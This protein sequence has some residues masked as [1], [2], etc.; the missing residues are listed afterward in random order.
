M[1]TSEV[2]EEKI[3]VTLNA[4]YDVIRQRKH[5]CSKYTHSSFMIVTNKKEAP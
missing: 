1:R 3:K 4:V 5:K 2:I